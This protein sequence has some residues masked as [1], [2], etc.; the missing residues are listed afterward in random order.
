MYLPSSVFDAI[1]FSPG[2][3]LT[4]RVFSLILARVYILQNHRC[5]IQGVSLSTHTG[6]VLS[7][8]LHVVV[9]FFRGKLLT[10]KPTGTNKNKTMSNYYIN[11]YAHSV[12]L[13]SLC[14]FFPLTSTLRSP[15]S[16]ANQPR[17]LCCLSESALLFIYTY[18]Q[19][20]KIRRT[21][22]PRRRRRRRKHE[23]VYLRPKPRNNRM[24]FC[25]GCTLDETRRRFLLSVG[26]T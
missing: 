8:C 21:S 14:F 13:R 4:T 16:P 17:I 23:I 9:G 7:V 19:K 12:N 22:L 20:K 5:F 24:E 11:Y 15:V 2:D 25:L 1:F 10:K 3:L 26:A 6:F 18:T